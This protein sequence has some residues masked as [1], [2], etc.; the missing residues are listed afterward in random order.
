MP[1]LANLFTQ[2][3]NKT[4]NRLGHLTT[5]VLLK[6][7]LPVSYWEAS[8]SSRQASVLTRVLPPEN[9][10]GCNFGINYGQINLWETNFYC[11]MIQSWLHSKP[12][13]LTVSHDHF[14]VYSRCVGGQQRQ[15]KAKPSSRYAMNLTHPGSNTHPR[16][17]ANYKNNN[18]VKLPVH[19]S[20]DVEHCRNI[21]MIMTWRLL[22][23]LKC[24]LAQGYSHLVSTLTTNA[25]FLK[26]LS[27]SAW[28]PITTCLQKGGQI[29]EDL[30]LSVE[31]ERQ[32]SFA[33]FA[34]NL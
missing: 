33:F 2:V 13:T 23:V 15:E 29:F 24:L 10:W 6:S 16:K 30:V 3:L 27:T 19:K 1:Y 28:I 21:W 14:T 18:S 34:N 32:L 20:K 11:E 5:T 4:W 31:F 25:F 9:H 22:Q 17:Q 12:M 8:V 26:L 7:K